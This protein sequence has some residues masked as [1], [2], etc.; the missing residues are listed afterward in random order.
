[1]GN[2]L[3]QLVPPY[4][5]LTDNIVIHSFGPDCV[6]PELSSHDVGIAS[7][8]WTANLAI[9]VPLLLA[10]SLLVTK[11][12]W[13]NGGTLNG[14][15]DVGVYSEDGVTKL[16]SCGPTANS[17]ANVVQS[18]VALSAVRL[19][20]NSRLW[21]ALASDSATQTYFLANLVIAGLDFIGI[22]QQAAG[23]SSGLLSSITFEIPT[24]A[25]FP[26]FG[27]TPFSVV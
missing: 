25:K 9:Y 14:N 20:A 1:M 10:E 13:C 26:M 7:T 21:L 4:G 12:F 8:A 2:V 11:F 17:G 24:V 16:A 27:F 22:K 23:Y 15:T 18:A 3:E 5:S 6:G 19:P